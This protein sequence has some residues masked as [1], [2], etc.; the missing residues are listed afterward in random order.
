MKRGL[1]L[2]QKEVPSAGATV[3]ISE[4]LDKDFKHLS[5]IAMVDF[6]GVRSVLLHSSLDGN[7]L[8][9]KDW[10]VASFQTSITV[11]PDE[12]YFTLEDRIAEG[13]RLEM[14]FKDGGTAANY[15]YT[16]KI[17]LRL[18]NENR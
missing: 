16:L 8:F 1:Q 12:R 11:P 4:E 7:E 13:N 14:E 10:E 9:P 17:N 2:I 15:P 18:S 6:E 3:R 5:G